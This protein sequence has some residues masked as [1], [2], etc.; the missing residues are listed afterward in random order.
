MPLSTLAQVAAA[1]YHI[2]AWCLDCRHHADLS[3]AEILR[4]LGRDLIMLDLSERRIVCCTRCGSRR[5]SVRLSD[6]HAPFSPGWHDRGT[7]GRQSEE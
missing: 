6:P 4:C 5:T 3:A 7:T 1:G 2:T